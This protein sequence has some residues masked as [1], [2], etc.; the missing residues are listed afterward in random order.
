MNQ[1]IKK[2]KKCLTSVSFNSSFIT[3]LNSTLTFSGTLWL[4]TVCGSS[5]WLLTATDRAESLWSS[6]H[7]SKENMSGR[8]ARNWL[9]YLLELPAWADSNHG[10]QVCICNHCR[11]NGNRVRNDDLRCYWKMFSS[12]AIPPT[13]LLFIYTLTKLF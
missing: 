5:R 9:L 11:E 8:T 12:S 7:V 6:S 10:D 13:T 4:V 3:Q 1:K 2:P